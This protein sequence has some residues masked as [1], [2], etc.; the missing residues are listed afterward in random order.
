MADE[1]KLQRV[2]GHSEERFLGSDVFQSDGRALPASR[3][4]G[5][6]TEEAREIDIYHSADVVVVGGGPAG[7]A[8]AWAAAK[9]GADV[10]LVERY[11]C[12]GGLSTGGLVM[13]IDRMTD[14]QGNHVIQ[15]FARHFIERMPKEGVA[16]PPPEDWG[17]T[18]ERRSHTGAS[19]PP[20]STASCNGRRR[21]IRSR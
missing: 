14:W 19:G 15:G 2:E 8:A 1:V 5:T 18:D 7:C 3:R 20:R 21:S 6:V 17:S 13:W 4:G 9:A 16:G 12:L 11:N 10:T